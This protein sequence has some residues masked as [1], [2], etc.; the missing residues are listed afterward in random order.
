MTRPRRAPYVGLAVLAAVLSLVVCGCGGSA[1]ASSPLVSFESPKAVGFYA[2][3]YRPRVARDRT[4]ILLFGGSDGG[5]FTDPLPAT[6][7]AHGYPVLDLAYFRE[8][9]LPQQL[10]GIRLEYFQRALRWLAGQPQVNPKRIVTFGVSRGGELSLILAA[11]FPAL[12][13]GAVGYVPSAY[14]AG[15]LPDPSKPAWTYRGNPVFGWPLAGTIPVQKI[16]GPVFVVGGGNDALW[17]SGMFVRTIAQEM[18][19]HGRRDVTA[20]VYPQAGH[21]LGYVLPL[22]SP[23]TNDKHVYGL[24]INANSPPLNLGGSAKADLAARKNAWPKLLAFLAH[25]TSAPS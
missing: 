14:V 19:D 10:E 25:I 3:W 23:P 6:L 15:G 4:A 8:P 1:R 16:D 24:I 13:H 22:P 2:R 9:G 20:L 21:L 17:P 5:L 12:I 7:A 11:S 18:R